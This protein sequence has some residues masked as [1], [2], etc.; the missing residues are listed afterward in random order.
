MSMKH[1]IESFCAFKDPMS[2][3][4][5][6]LTPG[7]VSPIILTP[8]AT[9]SVIVTTFAAVRG[10]ELCLICNGWELCVCSIFDRSG[11]LH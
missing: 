10:G 6:E 5:T 8:T 4:T 7:S 11:E 1:P 2:V 3:L 9:I